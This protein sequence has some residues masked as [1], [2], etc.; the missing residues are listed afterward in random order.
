MK[1]FSSNVQDSRRG[2]SRSVDFVACRTKLIRELLLS[3]EVALL[4]L[5]LLIFTSSI[6]AR[7]LWNCQYLLIK[8]KRTICLL[9]E[10]F[11]NI[12]K[13]Q[14]GHLLPTR[15]KWECY[16]F[17]WVYHNSMRKSLLNYM[18]QTLIDTIGNEFGLSEHEVDLT[19]TT[20]IN[21]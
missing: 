1:L 16:E 14:Y 17:V 12:C 13:S 3:P 10:I 5:L 4:L 15:H 9:F 19:N 18:L 20:N 21:Q 11:A 7:M 6:F 8:F 2:S